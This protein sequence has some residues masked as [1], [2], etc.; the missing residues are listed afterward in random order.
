MF[1]AYGKRGAEVV[2]TFLSSIIFIMIR[3]SVIFCFLLLHLSL[4]SQKE[5]K[6]SLELWTMFTIGNLVNTTAHECTAEKWP[7]K[8]VH[9]TGDTFWETEDEDAAFKSEIDFIEAHND[10]VWVELENRGFKSPKQEYEDDFQKERADVVAALKLFSE[11]P[12]FKTYNEDR[13]RNR[14]PNANIKKVEEGIYKIEM[15]SFDAENPVNTHK[16]EFLGI[17]DI[18]TKET[19]VQKL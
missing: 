15:G 7:I 2:E 14:F 1:I 9:K 4:F 16:K 19:T 12:L 6:D 18:K 17:I 3:L 13:L 11:S 10:S 5:E 8:L